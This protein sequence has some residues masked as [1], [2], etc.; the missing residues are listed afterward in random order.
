MKKNTTGFSIIFALVIVLIASSMSIYLLSFTIPYARNVKWLENSSQAYYQASSAVEESLW[1][2]SQNSLWYEN[3][4]SFT[5]GASQEYSYDIVAVWDMIPAVGQGNSDFDSDW[6]TIGFWSPL[7]LSLWNGLISSWGDVDFSFRV[8]DFDLNGN[9]SSQS[10]QGWATTP[11]VNWQLSSIDNTLLPNGTGAF[12]T[13]D[14]VNNNVSSIKLGSKQGIDLY[15]APSDLAAFYNSNCSW[16]NPC[17]LKIALLGNMNLSNV[18]STPIPYLEYKID[19]KTQ[20]IPTRFTDIFASGKSYGYR[21]DISVQI[22]QLT[23]DQAFDFT[24]FQ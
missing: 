7:Q 3:T 18:T 10:L 16:G 22:P 21:K 19:T 1:D 13:A 5:V 15:D 8:P 24:V 12:I 11:V 23:T 14:E 6:N 2:M 9:N 4:V 20:S 17:T